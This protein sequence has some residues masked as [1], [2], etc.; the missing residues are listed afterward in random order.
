MPATAPRYL[1]PFPTK[2]PLRFAVRSSYERRL[3]TTGPVRRGCRRDARVP[4]VRD[5]LL[6]RAVPGQ[7]PVYHP[8]VSEPVVRARATIRSSKEG[9]DTEAPESIAS[10]AS[11]SRAGGRGARGCHRRRRAADHGRTGGPI[12]RARTE[13]PPLSPTGVAACSHL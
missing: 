11:G 12:R 6:E 13:H 7:C 8:D 1:P 3:P 10:T 9:D 5:Y 4:S 2:H